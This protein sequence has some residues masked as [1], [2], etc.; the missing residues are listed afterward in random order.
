MCSPFQGFNSQTWSKDV[1][2]KILH[3]NTLKIL[4]IFWKFYARTYWRNIQKK[5]VLLLLSNIHD[6]K[7]CGL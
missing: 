1:I 5:N 4:K 7:T 6:I 3:L 2:F